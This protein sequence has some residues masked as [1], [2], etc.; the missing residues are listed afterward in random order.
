MYKS[1]SEPV[2]IA[3][4]SLNT[5]PYTWCGAAPEG[6][7]KTLGSHGITMVLGAKI[8][9]DSFVSFSSLRRK[10]LKLRNQRALHMK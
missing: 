4:V 5:G 6:W 7:K 2:V 3:R 10:R 9:R 8:L 1:V